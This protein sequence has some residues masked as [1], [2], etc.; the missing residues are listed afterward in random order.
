MMIMIMTIKGYDD[1]DVDV[2]ING[3]RHHNVH[4]HPADDHGRGD[5]HGHVWPSWYVMIMILVNND[6]KF[7]DLCVLSRCPG[8]GGCGDVLPPE[9]LH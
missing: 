6:V 8:N 2:M 7:D 4:N 1:D 9:R 5:D 3:Y